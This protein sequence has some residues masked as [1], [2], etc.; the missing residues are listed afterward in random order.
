MRRLL[1]SFVVLL[2]VAGCGEPPDSTLLEAPAQDGI[3]T[4]AAFGI[5]DGNSTELGSN[6]HFLFLSPIAPTTPTYAGVADDGLSPVVTVCDIT[7]GNW[8]AEAEACVA[9]EF[10]F[11]TDPAALRHPIQVNPGT[12]Y[13]VVWQKL[14]V[15]H[16]QLYVGTVVLPSVKLAMRHPE[17]AMS[18]AIDNLCSREA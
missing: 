8:D 9:P 13:T 17:G 16:S 3:I 4:S 7:N 6:E 11:S 15:I 14:F 1:G 10:E 2:S 5:F 18:N 12:G